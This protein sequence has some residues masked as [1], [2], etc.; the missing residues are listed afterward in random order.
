MRQWSLGAS[1]FRRERGNMEPLDPE[2]L[3]AL[4]QRAD[5]KWYAEH[6]GKYDYQEHLDFTV[7]Y[8]VGHYRNSH[9]KVDRRNHKQ[10]ERPGKSRRGRNTLRRENR[11]TKKVPGTSLRR[12]RN[13][14]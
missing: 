2:S 12:A 10:K 9:K 6:T 13:D 14:R 5:D 4:I 11:K 7:R 3:K 8:I 1:I